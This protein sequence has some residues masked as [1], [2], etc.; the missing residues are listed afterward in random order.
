[1]PLLTHRITSKHIPKTYAT[2]RSLTGANMPSPL[3]SHLIPLSCEAGLQFHSKFAH[4][5]NAVEIVTM[6]LQDG[7][8]KVTERRRCVVFNCV[9]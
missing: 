2:E 3:D 7:T 6:M 5:A 1:M 9:E 8:W 4:K